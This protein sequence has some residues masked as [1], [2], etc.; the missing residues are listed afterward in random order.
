MTGQKM[1]DDSDPRDRARR[2]VAGLTLE[3]QV[4]QPCSMFITLLTSSGLIA[5]RRRLL[6][7]CGYPKQEDSFP[8]DH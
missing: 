6:E 8:E 3:E 5:R 1:V 7:D 2:I 4:V